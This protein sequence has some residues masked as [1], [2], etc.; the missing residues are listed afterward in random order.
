M[1][2]AHLIMLYLIIYS[3]QFQFCNFLFIKLIH[4]LLSAVLCLVFTSLPLPRMGF[5]YMLKLVEGTK[6]WI[7]RLGMSVRN[8]LLW[9]S[10]ASNKWSWV[11]QST[12][13]CHEFYFRHTSCNEWS[14]IYRKLNI[15]WLS[16]LSVTYV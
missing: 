8:R 14:F 11:R 3:K 15:I 7:L 9:R 1:K 5:I 12:I 4:S 10:G 2:Q 6:T 16:S 13:S